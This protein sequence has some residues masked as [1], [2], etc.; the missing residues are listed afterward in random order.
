MVGELK[1]LSG[2]DKTPTVAMDSG[3]ASNENIAWLVGSGYDY[4]V[5][6]LQAAADALLCNR[7]PAHQGR[8]DAFPT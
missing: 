2:L 4:I 5:K 1:K 8:Q 3:L 7:M 6:S